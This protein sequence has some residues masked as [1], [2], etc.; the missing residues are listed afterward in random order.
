MI[1]LNIW[2]LFD[3]GK[4]DKMSW[5]DLLLLLV[6]AA[7]CGSLGQS[8]AGY[9]LGGFIVSI[10]LGFVGAWV[11]MWLAGQFGLPTWFVLTIDGKPFPVVWAIIGSALLSIVVGLLTRPRAIPM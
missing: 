4:E 11:G 5:L 9:S 8:I 2:P 7:I 1:S 3:S 6:I 10:V